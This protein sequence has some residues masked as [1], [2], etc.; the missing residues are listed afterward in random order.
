MLS[1][2]TSI[3]NDPVWSKVIATAIIG[4]LGFM[5]SLLPFVRGKLNALK[6]MLSNKNIIIFNKINFKRYL[7]RSNEVTLVL[8]YGSTW[9]NHY[10]TELKLFLDKKGTLLK[11]I[12]IDKE[13][14]HV[15]NALEE[16]YK[17]TTS[18]PSTINLRAK[19]VESQDAVKSLIKKPDPLHKKLLVKTTKLIPTYSLYKFDDTIFLVPYLY[20]PG[21]TLEIPAMVLSH[22]NNSEAYN[23]INNDLNA[24]FERYSSEIYS[25]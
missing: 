22:Q 12:F 10:N 4:F 2:V 14:E 11:C 24:L 5:F 18:D 3:W 13:S 25:A 23:Y 9:M 6:N 8:Q 17:L 1:F 15:I 16:K 20:S 21:R 7:S 19:I